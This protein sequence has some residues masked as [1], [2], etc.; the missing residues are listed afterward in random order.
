MPD[1]ILPPLDYDD[2]EFGDTEPEPPSLEP[3]KYSD[4]ELRRFEEIRRMKIPH[5]SLKKGID[6]VYSLVKAKLEKQPLVV[7]ALNRL[8]NFRDSHYGANAIGIMRALRD[9][10]EK[11]GVQCVAA[12]EYSDFRDADYSQQFP[13]VVDGKP[14]R[15]TVIMVL[16]MLKIMIRSDVK[17]H[18]F[19]R[20][21]LNKGIAKKL[22]PIGCRF[23][24]TDF[25]VGLADSSRTLYNDDDDYMPLADIIVHDGVLGQRANFSRR[26]ETLIN[27][28]RAEVS[29]RE[30]TKGQAQ[31]YDAQKILSDAINSDSP[32]VGY[33]AATEL[34]ALAEYR[35]LVSK[36]LRKGIRD[37][38]G[39][40]FDELVRTALKLAETPESVQKIVSAYH[41]DFAYFREMCE[42]E[43]C[44]VMETAVLNIRNAV[45]RIHQSFGF[46]CKLGF[47]GLVSLPLI[48]AA[49]EVVNRGE[50][51]LVVGVVNSGTPL[52][53]CT[54]LL[55]QS[56]A[57]LEWH[58]QWK[59]SPKWRYLETAK[60]RAELKKVLVAEI[61]A[62]S[63]QTL[64][65]IIPALEKLGAKQVDICFDGE[66]HEKSLS[67]AQEFP[68][69]TNA[70]ST[71]DFS[72]KA[73]CRNVL[74]LAAQIRPE[75][76]KT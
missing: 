59:G 21:L 25:I 22:N 69:F 43:E 26:C 33:E 74:H 11:E 40:Y 73:L 41:K 64:R 46:K 75:S 70:F 30:E 36:R 52:A 15:K 38:Y 31:S 1:R 53:I 45:R 19:H 48:N 72:P 39:L 44:A 4:E 17:Y 27:P 13:R 29:G 14:E 12:D 37:R 2:P 7:I 55:G 8:F 49:S 10:L 58:R 6:K 50:Y 34:D 61:D 67:V 60:K 65:A 16:D 24:G 18:D 63:G 9:R 68:F 32:F 76:D 66:R 57:Y 56:T 23:D 3:Y 28:R 62:V 47:D 42:V 35:E 71:H 51:D 20:E 54:E 5:F